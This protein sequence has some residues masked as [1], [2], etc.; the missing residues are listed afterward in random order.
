MQRLRGEL[1]AVRRENAALRVTLADVASA[2]SAGGGGAEAP[3]ASGAAAARSTSLRLACGRS[4]SGGA[5]ARPPATTVT[6]MEGSM[7][8]AFAGATLPFAFDD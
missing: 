5:P 6:S 3:A 8:S 2:A 1:E 4:R 7:V